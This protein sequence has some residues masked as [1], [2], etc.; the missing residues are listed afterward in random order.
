MTEDAREKVK[1]STQS[2]QF[3]EIES[4]QFLQLKQH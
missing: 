2:N 1:S 4:S 3:K